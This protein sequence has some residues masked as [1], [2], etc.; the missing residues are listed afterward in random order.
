MAFAFRAFNVVKDLCR[1]FGLEY[2]LNPAFSEC[3]L[4]RERLS[5]FRIMDFGEREFIVDD[6]A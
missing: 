2:E 1:L 4:S 6:V 3:N 5:R